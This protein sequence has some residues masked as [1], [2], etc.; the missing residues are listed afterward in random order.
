MRIAKL[1]PMLGTSSDP[2]RLVTLAMIEKALASDGLSFTDAGQQLR[3]FVTNILNEPEPPEV[4]APTPKTNGH[5]GHSG[6]APSWSSATPPPQQPPPTQARPQS[7]PRGAQTYSTRPTPPPP[8]PAVWSVHAAQNLSGGPGLAAAY[9]AR[10][11]RFLNLSKSQAR[12]YIR[13]AS[14]R[15]FLEDMYFQI[16]SGISPNSLTIRQADWLHDILNRAP[17]NF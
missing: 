4:A 13:N 15:Q 9:E 16:I 17:I 5:S 14:E 2:E 7:A 10:L 11:S 6:H 12:P 1:L 3:E 8:R